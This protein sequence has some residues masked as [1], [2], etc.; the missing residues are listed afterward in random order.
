VELHLRG[1]Y[2]LRQVR[3]S[4]CQMKYRRCASYINPSVHP[5]PR[6]P[7]M[8]SIINFQPRLPIM[9]NVIFFQ[10]S[11]ASQS[12]PPCVPGALAAAARS[13]QSIA[14]SKPIDQIAS[15]LDP[16]E[17]KC[18]I[19]MSQDRDEKDY[20]PKRCTSVPRGRTVGVDEQGTT[21]SCRRNY[22]C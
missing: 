1:V 18:T 4:Q 16:H 11:P 8:K 17:E 10:P 2:A 21:R 9:D 13:D 15:Q 5:L 22:C 12:Q 6:S 20:S 14:S 3:K 19:S 7:S